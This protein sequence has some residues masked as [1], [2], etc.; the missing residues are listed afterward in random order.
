MPCRRLR[1]ACQLTHLGLD[2]EAIVESATQIKTEN[3]EGLAALDSEYLILLL[4]NSW[5]M[6]QLVSRGFACQGRR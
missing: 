3:H 6:I 4:F 1:C 2:S 5:K